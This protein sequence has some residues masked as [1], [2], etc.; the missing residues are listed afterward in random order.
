MESLNSRVIV[1]VNLDEIPL[2]LS[3]DS[4]VLHSL[5]AKVNPFHVI[6][7]LDGVLIATRFNKGSCIGILHPKLEKFIKKCLAQLQVYIGSTT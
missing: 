3:V 5:V 2:T 7:N 4:E 1:V 6:F